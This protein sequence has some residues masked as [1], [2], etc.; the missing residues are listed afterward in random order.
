[1]SEEISSITLNNLY[2]HK[3]G[4]S[5]DGYKNFTDYSA[6]LAKG[7]ITE[8]N[9]KPALYTTSSRGYAVWIDYNRNGNFTDAGELVF[10]QSPTTSTSITG[11]FTVPS[12]ALIGGTRMR[13]SMKVSGIPGPCEVGFPN[14]EVEDYTVNITATARPEDTTATTLAFNVY[15]NPV[16]NELYFSLDN[17]MVKS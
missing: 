17:I 2:N 5:Q 1:M 15:P 11:N 6:I 12:N 4:T 8:I 7:E 14:G 16:I 3:E 10:S 9:I 13:V